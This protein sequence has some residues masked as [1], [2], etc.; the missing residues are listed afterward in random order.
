MNAYAS[1]GFAWTASGVFKN[2]F[3]LSFGGRGGQSILE[4]FFDD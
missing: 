2:N 3:F 1:A 4:D